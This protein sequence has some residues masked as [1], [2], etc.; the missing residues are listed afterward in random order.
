MDS[1]FLQ[2][3]EL[4]GEPF[5]YEGSQTGVL[6]LHGFTAT[7]AEVRLLADRL[8]VSGYTIHAPLLPGHGTKPEDLN[9]TNYQDWID[10]V[11]RS[12]IFLA[13]K[14]SE[15]FV[16]GESM[17]ALLSLYLAAKHADIAGVICFSP[18]LVVKYIW[19]AVFLQYFIKAIP[20]SQ[21]GDNLPWKGYK[22]N[23]SKALVQ[24]FLLQRNVKSVLSE[25]RQPLCVFIAKKDS[26]VS[27]EAGNYVLNHVNS[28]RK[29]IHYLDESP[30]CMILAGEL[31]VIS[32]ITN[33]FIESIQKDY[34]LS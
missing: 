3:I 31:P 13:G 6:L 24:L 22:V 11:E 23:P 15:I 2:N 34:S 30:H 9:K 32:S 7:T 14:C 18:A 21:A 12:Y 17:G 20:K 29:E 16:A 27:P 25:I 28:I 8:R 33:G 4:D 19:A 5:T 26:R 10:E 1:E